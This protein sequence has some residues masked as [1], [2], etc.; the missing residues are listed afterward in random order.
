MVDE[1]V[2]FSFKRMA[3]TVA[4]SIMLLFLYYTLSL[5]D[6]WEAFS[7]TLQAIFYIALILAAVFLI[8]FDL[9]GKIKFNR[10]YMRRRFLVVTGAMLVGILLSGDDF[11]RLTT[12]TI[13]PRALFDYEKPEIIATLTPPLYLGHDTV[14]KELVL[15]DGEYE[16]I[17]PIYEGSVLDI[18]VTGTLWA[19]EVLLSDGSKIHFEKTVENEFIA[20][21]RI[22]LQ[23]SWALKQGSYTIGEWPI[24]A[25]DDKEPEIDLFS[26]EEYE[27]DKG[28]LAFKV[29]VD[30]DRKV[31]KAEIAII[32]EDGIKEEIKPLA[33]RNVRSI[34]SIYYADFS[35]SQMAG[36]NADIVLTVEDEAGQRTAAVLENILLPAKEYKHPVAR[37]LI[38][39]RQQLMEP[40]YDKKRILRHIK[41]LGL[42]EEKEGLPPIYYMALRSAYWRLAAPT[43]ENDVVTARDLL[44]DIAQTLED[45]GISV[46]ESNLLAALDELRL[47]IRQKKEVLDIREN[48]RA[49]DQ[50]F[51]EYSFA[52]SQ[53]IS[54]RYDL[55]I[56]IKALRRLYSYILAFSDQKKFYNASLIVDFMAKELVQNDDLIFSRDGLGNYFALSESRQII[57]N[58]I[59]IQKTLLASAYNEQMTD[60]IR[61]K[62]IKVDDAKKQENKKS[63]IALQEKVGA[64]VKMLGDKISFSGST[65]GFLISNATDLIEEIL[66]SMKESQT[67]EVTQSQSELIAVMSNLKRVLNKPVSRSPELQNIL[68]EINSEPVT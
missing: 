2:S 58:L 62:R 25:I 42:L 56:D 46:I 66:L 44:W 65:S 17:N 30:D 39:L 8:V 31:M 67:A 21:A 12:L 4:P 6:I 20:S 68:K 3:D 33:I 11:D 51:K 5:F 27:N 32:N 48:L 13:K 24:I 45:Q 38:A 55:E 28:Y 64:A 23:T 43:E 54:N 22:G 14:K 34:N 40:S 37:N 49:V 60:K 63:Q 35:G 15:S 7:P 36:Q 52:A 29:N 41:A 18:K 57:D 26:L 47:A 59:K 50:L 1:K 16:S 53:N 19:P 61:S 10:K 9:L